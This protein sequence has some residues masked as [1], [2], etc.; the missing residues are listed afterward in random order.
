MQGCQWEIPP[1]HKKEKQHFFNLL[2]ISISLSSCGSNDQG[3]QWEV[4]KK[5]DLHF[6]VSLCGCRR[7]S[8]P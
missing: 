2:K 3:C 7:R 4:I 6:V 5:A 1:G 8:M